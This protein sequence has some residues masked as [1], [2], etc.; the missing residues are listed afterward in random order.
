MKAFDFFLAET[1]FG[2]DLRV[3]PV[4]YEVLNVFFFFILERHNYITSIALILQ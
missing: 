2:F 4:A 3:P 1:Y